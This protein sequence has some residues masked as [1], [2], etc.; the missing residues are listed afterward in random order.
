MTAL[1]V[2]ILADEHPPVQR[3]EGLGGHPD[4]EVVGPPADEWVAV[5]HDVADARRPVFVPFLAQPVPE[6]LNRPLARFDEQLDPIAAGATVVLTDGEAQEVEPL[7][8]V[9]DAGFGGR[10]AQAAL[11]QPV[12]QPLLHA[13]GVLAALTEDHEVE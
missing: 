10:E 11:G 13:L 8:Q 9:D 2:A 6:G 4:P 12:V 5:P 3:A 7:A 1:G